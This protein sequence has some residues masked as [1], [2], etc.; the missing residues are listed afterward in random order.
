[1]TYDTEKVTESHEPSY[2]QA[3]LAHRLQTPSAI[4]GYVRVSTPRQADQ[5]S[6]LEGQADQ[7]R[8]YAER[9]GYDLKEIYQDVGSAY[10]GG[11]RPGLRR[12]MTEALRL[13]APL[14]VTS[15]SRLCRQEVVCRE[16]LDKRLDII[17]VET[18]RVSKRRLIDL[19][20]KAEAEARL[21]SKR[22]RA[23]FARKRA[24]GEKL[25]NLVSLPAASQKG[26]DANKR[27]ARENDERLADYLKDT[28]GAVDLSHRELSDALNSAG[29]LNLKSA[30]RG[31]YEPWT[32]GSIRKPRE[33]AMAVLEER[34]AIAAGE[35]TS[36]TEP[37]VVS[38]GM[39]A[40]VSKI[41]KPM[42]ATAE[43]VLPPV[44]V[45]GGGGGTTGSVVPV[46][47]PFG[48]SS[49]TVPRSLSMNEIDLLWEIVKIRN[50]KRINVL[51]ELGFNRSH[52]AIWTCSYN[53][54]RKLSPEF[55]NPL[56]DWLAKHRHLVAKSA[57]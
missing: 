39:I 12:A 35:Q 7:I 30:K 1:M 55:L 17:C 31:H 53:S 27:R 15:I 19:A 41:E 22:Q 10:K 37:S 3:D 45:D 54:A 34:G 14:C 36:I 51:D 28:P 25:G 11:I 8:G 24:K 52:V 21:N 33:R 4:L 9:C 5:G 56:V 20:A 57:V 50:L 32:L 44:S 16:L 46:A 23:A 26:C 49:E 2:L 18:G 40:P 29:L 43:K 13:D 47:L 6:S 48:S 42:E 38:T